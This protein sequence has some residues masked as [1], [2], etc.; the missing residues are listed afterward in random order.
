MIYCL[1]VCG[2]SLER[3]STFLVPCYQTEPCSNIT[4]SLL[5][6]RYSI[7]SHKQ[8]AAPQLMAKLFAKGCGGKSCYHRNFVMEPQDL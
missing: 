8:H 7:Q 3:S 1:P 4:V 6:G 5:T 2:V